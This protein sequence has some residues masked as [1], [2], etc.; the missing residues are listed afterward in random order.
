MEVVDLGRRAYGP[1]LKL[2]EEYVAC[3]RAGTI[4]DTLLLVEHDPVFTLGRSAREANLLWTAEELAR[5]GI[6]VFRTG[7]GGD[8]TYHGPGQL[9]GYPIVDLAA[10][11]RGVLWYVQTLE[12][13]LVRVL[14]DFGI[15]GATDRR[16]R[17]VWVG[18]DKV[19]AIGVRVTHHIT[20]HGFAL[21]VRMDMANYAG[22]IPC[23]IR[24]KGVTSLHL[25]APDV[26]ME[27]AKA[28]VVKRFCEAMG[29][30]DG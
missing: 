24:D 17:G 26:T 8:V 29:K 25:L 23:G 11:R 6:E 28:S 21:N 12:R 16:N 10:R 9:V 5:R 1:A 4:P 20:M 27:E 2:Q 7:R 30:N 18:R 22:I 19:A 13:V 14:G 3:R 15:E